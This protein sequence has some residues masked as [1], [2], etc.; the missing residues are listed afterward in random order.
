MSA[1]SI[2]RLDAGLIARKGEAAPAGLSPVRPVPP[3]APHAQPPVAVRSD[4][5]A[6]DANAASTPSGAQVA[7]TVKLDPERYQRLR[8]HGAKVRRTNQAILQEALD[9]YLQRHAD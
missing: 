7:V 6:P 5:A 8:M 4:A 2:S 1:R 9:A 3:A